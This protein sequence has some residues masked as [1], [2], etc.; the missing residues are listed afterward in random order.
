MWLSQA[1]AGG[2]DFCIDARL[3]ATSLKSGS[4]FGF[5]RPDMDMG[6]EDRVWKLVRIE[7]KLGIWRVGGSNSISFRFPQTYGIM[8]SITLGF[9][10]C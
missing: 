4:S 8:A 5:L 1:S 2:K 3:A 10:K 7:E 9:G 6:G